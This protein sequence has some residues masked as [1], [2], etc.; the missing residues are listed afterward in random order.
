MVPEAR[1]LTSL[2]EVVPL[3]AA[4]DALA[5][6]CGRPYAAPAWMLSW[7]RTVPRGPRRLR[8]VA[9]HE[10]G[11]L[12]GVTPFWTRPLPGGLARYRLLARR[13]AHRNEPLTAA[14]R[15]EDVARAVAGALA[16]A[17]PRPGVID[18]EGVSDDPPWAALLAEHWPGRRPALE[19][20]ERLVAPVIALGDSFETWAAERRSKDRSDAAR[21]QRRLTDAGGRVRTV[22]DA[23]ELGA[24]LAATLRAHHGH[25]E[26]RGGSAVSARAERMAGEAAR[27]LFAAGRLRMHVMELGGETI[28]GVVNVSAG[29]EVAGWLIGFSPAAER[30]APTV[31]LALASLRDAFDLGAER[32]DLGSGEDAYK[33]RLGG[34]DRPVVSQH[35]LPAAAVPRALRLAPERARVVWRKLP[36]GLRSTI[37]ARIP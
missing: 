9:V 18:L 27:E 1:I 2:A 7:W 37:R 25:W 23:A 31:Q 19:E 12:I 4:W 3:V 16:G 14:G 22:D 21:R 8:I 28:A 36:K 5:V 6:R 26:R 13:S 20:S 34:V 29:P 35:V 30:F 15:T 10:G 33:F 32:F 17:S 24:A 11:E